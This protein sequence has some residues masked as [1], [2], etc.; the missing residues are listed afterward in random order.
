[1]CLFSSEK[2]ISSSIRYRTTTLSHGKTAAVLSLW[3]QNSLFS[4]GVTLYLS[5]GCFCFSNNL[6]AGLV[7][8]M[9]ASRKPVYNL[10]L[11]FSLVV[12][13]YILVFFLQLRVA[14]LLLL[15]AYYSG[16]FTIPETRKGL[17]S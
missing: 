2:V 6:Y 9:A 4:V 13:G 10:C 12:A 16:M 11:V 15:S 3:S 8:E 5:G 1:M 17:G 7:T 14:Q